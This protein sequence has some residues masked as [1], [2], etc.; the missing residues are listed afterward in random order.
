VAA[1]AR[2]MS[3]ATAG[4][5]FP[6]EPDEAPANSSS[7]SSSADESDHESGDGVSAAAPPDA[8]SAGQTAASGLIRPGVQQ[9]G[10]AG[11]KGKL[12]RGRHQG[13]QEL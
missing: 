8:G 12:R 4:M 3:G 11:G 9:H 2:Q 1:A 7:S 6:G 10:S 13:I 5:T